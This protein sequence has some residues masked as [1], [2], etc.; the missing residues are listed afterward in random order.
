MGVIHLTVRLRSCES[1]IC[2][3]LGGLSLVRSVFREVWQP[4]AGLVLLAV[5]LRRPLNFEQSEIKNFEF[6]VLVNG[7]L[8]A[9]D[10]P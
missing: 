3:I 9:F 4:L 2:V 7:H 5:K 8:R 6:G 1:Y 10:V